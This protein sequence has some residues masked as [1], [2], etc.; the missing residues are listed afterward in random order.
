MQKRALSLMLTICM[1]AVL[2]A[3]CSDKT[4]SSS[5][6]GASGG[7]VEAPPIEKEGYVLDWN[8]EFDG[9]EL[10]TKKWLPQYLPHNTSSDSGCMTNYEMGDGTLKL[11]IDE[12]T[13]E[14]F[15]GGDKGFKVSS[16]Q[17]YEKNMLHNTNAAG[18]SVVPYDSYTTQYGYFETR[19]KMPSCGGGGHVAWWMI[20]TQYDARE[21][22]TGSK[23]N[24]EIDVT[25]TFLSAPNLQN[26]KVH[27]WSDEDMFEWVQEVPLEGDFVNEWHT[28][29]MEWTPE[30]LAFFVDG[31]EIARTNQSP[32]YEMCILL[33]MYT[34]N[35][36]TSNYWSGIDNGVYPKV[37]EIDYFRVYKAEGGYPD[38]KTKPSEPEPDPAVDGL[39]VQEIKSNIL[40][41]PAADPEFSDIASLATLTYDAETMSG[42]GLHHLNSSD[43]VQG[44]YSYI[45][46][47]KPELPQEFTFTWDSPQSFNTVNLYSWYSLGQAPTIIELQTQKQG[48]DEW[49]SAAAYKVTWKTETDSIEYAQ[50]EVPDADNITGLKIV[51][52]GANLVWDHYVICKVH[53]YKQ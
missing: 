51:V 12:N 21:D 42:S 10:D 35:D 22:G 9:T 52:R 7:S 53:V 13:P 17:T 33:S 18:A 1:G 50:M 32:Q 2:F 39:D 20:G 16:I 34:N 14:Y 23:Q 11:I 29:G 45:S 26:P 40:I 24:A 15:N 31:V 27:A 4:P 48:S 19:Y 3:G 30:Y 49:T 36:E 6:G 8:D 44:A 43:K 41:D 47:D 38:A 5:G 25:E 28:Y 37:W 46:E